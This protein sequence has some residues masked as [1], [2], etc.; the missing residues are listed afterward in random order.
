MHVCN[1]STLL[2]VETG[3]RGSKSS[4]GT[5]TVQD[6]LGIHETLSLKKNLIQRRHPI[7]EYK[8]SLEDNLAI[9][10]LSFKI[11]SIKDGNV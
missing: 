7:K 4:S 1:P 2:E 5:K 11:R 6:Q 9:E 8:L 3:I 10:E